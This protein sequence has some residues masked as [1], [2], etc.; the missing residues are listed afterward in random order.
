[1]RSLSQRWRGSHTGRDTIL[2]LSRSGRGL[3]VSG[4]F[5]MTVGAQATG[6]R[7][8]LTCSRRA[9]SEAR[10]FKISAWDSTS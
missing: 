8:L 5:S 1:M 4:C 9:G 7:T 10:A 2:G 3:P 6:A